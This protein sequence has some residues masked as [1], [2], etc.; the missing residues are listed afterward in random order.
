MGDNIKKDRYAEAGVDIDAGNALVDR[1]KPAAA[2]TARPGVMAGLGG[3]GAL[4][5][6]KAAGYSDPVLVAAQIVVSLQSIVSRNI[7]PLESGV[8]TVGAIHGGS[9][10]NIISDRVEMQLTVRSDTPEVREQLLDGI[11]RVAAGVA[12]S[13]GPELADTVRP[14]RSGYL[15][16]ERRE[17]EA[18]LT[19]G[20]YFRAENAAQALDFRQV[21]LGGRGTVRIDILDIIRL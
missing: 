9:K 6:L 8:I 17:I 21:P 14:Y 16:A 18:E 5:D 15:A 2:A 1:I 4:F 3:F 13:L 10:H 11:D 19:G 12:R 20:S 7:G